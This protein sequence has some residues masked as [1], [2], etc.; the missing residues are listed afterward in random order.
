MRTRSM[1]RRPLI[2]VAAGAA[3]VLLTTLLAAP[4]HAE[5]P[6][7]AFVPSSDPATAAAP[8]WTPAD[9]DAGDPDVPG[10]V[11]FTRPAADP[12]RPAPAPQART[13][14]DEPLYELRVSLIARDGRPG[15]GAVK[16]FDVE[17]GSVNAGRLVPGTAPCSTA[18]YAEGPCVLVPRGTYAVLGTVITNAAWADG[19][20]RLGRQL[21]KSLVGDPELTVDGDTQVTLDA[22]KANEVRVRT[23]GH[24]TKAGLGGLSHYGWER[25][26]DNG[27][28]VRQDYQNSRGR[29]LEERV[30]MQPTRPVEHGTFGAYTRWRLEAPEIKFGVLGLPG[31]ALRPEYYAPTPFS[32][33][34][35]QF[36]RL[37]G[38]AELRPVDAG[39]GTA[40]AG[41]DLR[42]RLAVIRRDDAVPVSTQSN[43]AAA[44]GARMVAIYNDAPGSND[45][46]GGTGVR[47]RVPTVRLSGEEGARLLAATRAGRTVTATGQTASPYLYDLFLRERG[48]VRTDPSHTV[49]TDELTRVD[50]DF[51][52]QLAG[53][54]AM[55]EGRYAFQPHDIA[56]IASLFPLTGLPRTRTDYVTPDPDL[57]YH[58]SVQTPDSRYNN[59]FPYE[60]TPTIRLQR[61]TLATYAAPG[62]APD[63]AWHKAPQAPGPKRRSPVVRQGDAIRM[64]LAGFAGPDGASGDAATSGFPDGLT[65][66]FRVFR[67]GQQ[68]VATGQTPSGTIATVPERAAYRIAYDVRNDAVWA[69]LSTRTHTEWAFDSARPEPGETEVLPLVRPVFDV[70]LDGRNRAPAGRQPLRL[71]LERQPGAAEHPFTDV[72]LDLSYDDG[73]TWTPAPSLRPIANDR[74]A[75]TTAGDAAKGRPYV[76]LRVRAT[77]SA[78]ATLTQEIIRAY[79]SR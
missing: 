52:T 37:Q 64:S 34:I 56:A 19:A 60:R 11:R 57:R 58:T 25:T 66:D 31:D 67:D 43:D 32:D 42:G 12:A 28:A 1:R 71:T 59:L 29:Q 39:D 63:Q 78:G 17:D 26:A 6:G 62:R 38:R 51:H 27:A 30:F 5:G 13:T 10:R 8:G 72:A 61:A 22:R 24:E 73:A 54:A 44:A 46:T 15:N 33:T 48:H 18:S 41:L 23:P 76:S 68:V 50:N 74:Y 7:D 4:A 45:S 36:P 69:R 79:A 47:L 49:R 40:L 16:V 14:A 21:N 3:L 20:D 55:S 70:P 35:G 2:P 75:T 77:D 53:N 65:T 9:G